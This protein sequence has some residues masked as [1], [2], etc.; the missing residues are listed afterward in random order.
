MKNT[1]IILQKENKR[2]RRLIYN[3][4]KTKMLYA[5]TIDIAEELKEKIPY[6]KCK[7]DM[8]EYLE[9]IIT[10]KGEIL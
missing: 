8:I 6:L 10:K 1:L 9:T 5:I 3:K 4:I 2:G 7:E